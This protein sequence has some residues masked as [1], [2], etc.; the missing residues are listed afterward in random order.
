MS[1]VDLTRIEGLDALTVQTILSEIG[2]D[3][4]RFEMVKHFTSW[5]GLAPVNDIS[6]GKMLRS[7]TKKPANRAKAFRL[8][9]Q[10][11]SRNR[12]A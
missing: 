3:M 8:A 2:L 4:S 10:L 12:S 11:V 7:K 6:G 9:A 5:L 1:G